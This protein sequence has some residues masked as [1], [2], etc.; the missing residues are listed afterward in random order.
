MADPKPLGNNSVNSTYVL[1]Q[2]RKK[3]KE[4]TLPSIEEKFKK[5]PFADLLEE[6]ILYG[7]V[8][9]DNNIITPN[10]NSSNFLIVDVNE[11]KNEI[12]FDFVANAFEDLKKYLKNQV[13]LGFISQDSPMHEMKVYKSFSPSEDLVINTNELLANSFKNYYIK[14]LM[15]NSKITDHK[16]F[17]KEFFKYLDSQTENG[18]SVTKTGIVLKT[19]FLNLSSG[20]MLHISNKKADDDTVKYE[21]FLNTPEFDW[22]RD[23]CIRFGF[24]I[25]KNVPW[26]IIADLESPNMKKYMLKYKINNTKE[27]FEKRYKKVHLEEI[28]HFK[29]FFYLSYKFYLIDNLPY[30]ISYDKLCAKEI[31]KENFKFRNLIS[32]ADFYKDFPDRYWLRMYF[33]FR[34]KE[35]NRGLTQIEFDNIFRQASE[36]IRLNKK[37]DALNY[38]NDFF[39]KFEEYL[40]LKQV[41]NIDSVKKDIASNI[42]KPKII[43]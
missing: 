31:S 24:K 2:D 25:D 26:R 14:N 5:I 28:E 16:S 22:Y 43:F 42:K 40:F 41:Q 6:N 34:N 13:I 36:L 32:E 33:Y 8:D 20:L 18:I 17:N 30:N 19:N 1:F 15:L 11:E 29:K 9:S 21:D 39:K 38:I 37:E 7:M 3:Y 10:N 35:T 27:L 12:V 23:S 4:V